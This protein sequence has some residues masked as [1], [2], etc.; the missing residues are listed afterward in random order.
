MSSVSPTPSFPW[1]V[2]ES[3]IDSWPKDAAHDRRRAMLITAIAEANVCSAVM[4]N[5]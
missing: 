3:D 1:Q 5:K 4:D 2:K